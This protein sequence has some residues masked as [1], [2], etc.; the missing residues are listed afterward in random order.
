MLRRCYGAPHILGP[1]H[2]LP[3]DFDIAVLPR[4]YGLCLSVRAV[5][6]PSAPGLIAVSILSVVR[7]P[8][9]GFVQVRLA[10]G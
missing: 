3:C 1:P 9:V 5:A 4:K 6:G 8:P 7:G 2:T 10:T